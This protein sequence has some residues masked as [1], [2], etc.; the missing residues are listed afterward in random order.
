MRAQ[1]K[2]LYSL[3]EIDLKNFRPNAGFG[4]SVR[5]IVGPEN[6]EG[7]ESFDF[8]VCTPDWFA[9]NEIPAANAM[10]IGRHFLFVHTYDYS[11]LERFVRSY[12]QSSEG[13][14]WQVIAEKISRL[15]AWEFEDYDSS[16]PH[17]A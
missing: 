4:I 3:S 6:A 15:G 2:D 11:R 9:T 12:C 17:T 14:S 7:E 1:L 8:T 13:E 16:S 5:A 10:K